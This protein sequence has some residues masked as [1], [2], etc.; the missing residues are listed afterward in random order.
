MQHEIGGERLL[1]RR[2]EALDELMRQPPDEADRVRDEVAA[3]VV[4]ESRASS[5][6]VSRR[7]GCG[8]RPRRRSAHSGA[9][10]SRRSCSRRARRS[11]SGSA[12][13][14]CAW[15][16]AACSSSLRR[17]LSIVIRRRASRRSVSSW[18]SPGPRVPT[19]PPTA[20][21]PP[22]S[23]SRCCHMP[24]MRGRLYSSCASSTCSLPSALRAC[25]A[26]MSRISCV[27]STTRAV[28]ASSSFRC[29]AGLSSSSTSSESARA[30]LNERESSA[31]FPL[32]T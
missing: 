28:R 23:R 26:K 14:P 6:R 5:D 4:L 20:P 7:G 24:R 2:R 32:P 27:R 30:S 12:R 19:P 22:P 1:E 29:C 13:A 21:V 15:S 16:R 31:S 8:P 10:T 9:S 18:L 17:R 3:P 11:A 25:W